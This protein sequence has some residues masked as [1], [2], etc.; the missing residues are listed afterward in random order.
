MYF[1]V[2]LRIKVHRIHYSSLPTFKQSLTKC[3]IKGES[4]VESTSV[5]FFIITCLYPHK[6]VYLKGYNRDAKRMVA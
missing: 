3:L 2:K 4:T 6:K 1:F 5:F